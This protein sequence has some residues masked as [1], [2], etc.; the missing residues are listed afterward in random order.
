[1]D[2]SILDFDIIFLLMSQDKKEKSPSKYESSFVL[3]TDKSVL[4]FLIAH[5]PQIDFAM[6]IGEKGDLKEFTY[7]KSFEGVIDLVEQKYI[8]KLIGLRYR[9]ADFH[10]IQGGL[11]ISVDVFK[12]SCIAVTSRD[13]MSMIVII[14]KLTNIE[15]IR[16]IMSQIN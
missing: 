16:Q 12:D 2:K 9:I 14:T 8:A 10:K 11:K 15:N 5:I 7:P 4:E 6:I 13:S 1:M 3:K